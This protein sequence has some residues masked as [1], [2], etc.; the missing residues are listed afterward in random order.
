MFRRALQVASLLLVVAASAQTAGVSEAE[1]AAPAASP[2]E[3]VRRFAAELN[4]PHA[5]ARPCRLLSARLIPLVDSPMLTG[6]EPWLAESYTPQLRR[7]GC[8]RTVRLYGAFSASDKSGFRTHVEIHGLRLVGRRGDKVHLC[9]TVAE[10]FQGQRSA[11]RTESDVFLLRERGAWRIVSA[12][13]LWHPW[14]D[15]QLPRSHAELLSHLR[16]LRGAVRGVRAHERRLIGSYLRHRAPVETS[17]LP[18][19]GPSS[20]ADD[21]LRDVERGWFGRRVRDQER[22]AVDLRGAS[23][24]TAGGTVAFELRF[25]GSV[26]ADC[27][28]VL[29]LTELRRRPRLPVPEPIRAEWSVSLHDGWASAWGGEHGLTALA[30]LRASAVGDTLRLVGAADLIG[31]GFDERRMPI[32]LSR[33]LAWRVAAVERIP[34]GTGLLTRAATDRLPNGDDPADADGIGHPPPPG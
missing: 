18:W 22:P 32:D 6:A 12:G 31:V 26:P 13:L 4:A 3:V 24:S 23:L 17:P 8:D 5:S 27:S 28:I 11:Q 1:G 10:R 21:P 19:T 29:T 9:V 2:A 16:L 15:L 34:G 33:P 14:T 7:R 25:R 20:S 30:G